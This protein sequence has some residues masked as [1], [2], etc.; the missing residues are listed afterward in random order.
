[1]SWREACSRWSLHDLDDIV[2]A[3]G[4]A[5]GADWIFHSGVK[6]LKDCSWCRMIIFSLSLQVVVSWEKQNSSQVFVA[7]SCI[8]GDIFCWKK[9]SKEVW[10]H[11]KGWLIPAANADCRRGENKGTAKLSVSRSYMSSRSSRLSPHPLHDEPGEL[12]NLTVSNNME[13]A[14]GSEEEGKKKKQQ[15]QD[16]WA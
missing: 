2:A 3:G 5:A 12:K 7:L 6:L 1:M 10:F 16:R 4:A 14:L 9:I 11:T 13:W 15:G 8:G